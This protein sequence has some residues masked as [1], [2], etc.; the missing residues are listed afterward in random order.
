MLLGTALS[1]TFSE[2]VDAS[3]A[4]VDFEPLIAT[5]LDTDGSGRTLFIRPVDEWRVN[6]NYE[7]TLNIKSK[8]G[9]SLESPIEFNFKFI[10]PTGPLIDESNVR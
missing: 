3:S 8:T 1:F 6:I 5:E 7:L 2:P 9:N 4:S 10:E